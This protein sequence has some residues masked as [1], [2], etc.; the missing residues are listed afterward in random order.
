MYSQCL[1]ANATGLPP[2]MRGYGGPCDQI[3]ESCRMWEC[4][5]FYVL[6]EAPAAGGAAG[7]AGGA[8]GGGDIAN[9]TVGNRTVAA[10]TAVG[11]GSGGGVAVFKYSD[12]VGTVG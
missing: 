7:A 1:S 5:G 9:A 6:P 3:G 10:A 2:G 8:A 11:G 12:Q 4:P